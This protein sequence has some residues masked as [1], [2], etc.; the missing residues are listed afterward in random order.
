MRL[1]VYTCVIGGY[2]RVFPPIRSAYHVD[3]LLVTD[4]PNVEVEGWKTLIVNPAAFGSA[5]LANRYHKMLMHRVRPGYDVSLYVDGNIRLLGDMARFVAN[6]H[7]DR[8]ALTLFRHDRRDSVI[9]EIEICE[10]LGKLKDPL[11]ARSRLESFR[12]EGFPDNLGLVEA[13]VLIK[14]H[15]HA[16]T[17]VIMS[18]WW[19]EYSKAPTR[20][21]LSLPHVLWK[22][23]APVGYHAFNY[24]SPN[25]WFGIYPHRGT[26]N[27]TPAYAD[28]CA[29][30]YDSTLHRAALRCW[31]TG[32]SLRRR[33]RR[34]LP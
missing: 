16:V 5:T 21:Q 26:K 22:S 13:G 12:E 6:T 20:D 31:K 10:K 15:R 19:A 4:D 33:L 7:A 34:R 29:R 27:M 23:R 3:H 17:D 28:L 30:S 18:E 2:D 14:D 8:N 9:E 1:L 24:R 32:R 25:P 11:L